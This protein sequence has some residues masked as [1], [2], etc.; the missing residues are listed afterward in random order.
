MSADADVVTAVNRLMQ[1]FLTLH[2][3][4]ARTLGVNPVDLDALMH[5][6][7]DGPLTQEALRG[8]LVLSKSAMTALVE[9]LVRAGLVER[10]ANPADRRS[11]HLAVSPQAARARDHGIGRFDREVARIAAGLSPEQLATI[12]AFLAELADTQHRLTEEVRRRDPAG[13]R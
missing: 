8:R 10:R 5:L 4:L 7:V 6:S 1:S 9:R 3:A 2:H 12:T 13:P 11:T